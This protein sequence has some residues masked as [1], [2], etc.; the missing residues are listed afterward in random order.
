MLNLNYNPLLRSPYPNHRSLPRSYQ[1]RPTTLE[2]M[3][4]NCPT[5]FTL[6]SSNLPLPTSGA[7]PTGAIL[8]VAVSS[9]RFYLVN[10]KEL[11]VFS[12]SYSFLVSSRLSGWEARIMQ[13]HKLDVFP[14]VDCRLEGEYLAVA[15]ASE[16][17]R[18]EH[19]CGV[20]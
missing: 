19:V 14:S 10:N 6:T 1:V 17:Q 9:T 13:V 15:A 12:N 18:Q 8:C 20:H 7:L 16:L 4:S 5:N 11:N 2:K 3:Y